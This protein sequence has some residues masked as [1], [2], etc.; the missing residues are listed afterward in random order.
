MNPI[1]KEFMGKAIVE[2]QGRA[3]EFAKYTCN[4]YNGCSGM[5]S[6]CM[7]K[8]SRF[9]K[10]IGGNVPTLKKTLVNNQEALR[11]TKSEILKNQEELR[12]YGLFFTFNS[13]PCLRE[14]IDLTLDT[15][16]FC[17]S[18]SIPTMILTKQTWWTNFIVHLCLPK[19]CKIGYTLTGFDN[20]ELGCGTN[21]E[22]VNSIKILSESNY[23]TWASIEPIIDLNKSL[24][25]IKLSKAYV[26]HYKIGLLK[27]KEFS[28]I[29]IE[30]FMVDVDHLIKDTGI[31]IYYKDS[32]ITQFGINRAKLPK[33][34]VSKHIF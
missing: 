26:K 32:I 6:Y 28:K 5:C 12:K 7:N 33:Y 15:I 1:P 3:N 19:S 17:Y 23:Y 31:T 16:W 20:L 24:Q 25:M 27:G 13:D 18:L 14:T 10:I 11:I 9:S 34:C 22:R 30:K 8:S 21:I 2:S 4:Q 29:D